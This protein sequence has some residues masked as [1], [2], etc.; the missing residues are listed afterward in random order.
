[1]IWHKIQ[2][3]NKVKKNKNN[4]SSSK[5]TRLTFHK[6]QQSNVTSMY[7]LREELLITILEKLDLV[8]LRVCSCGI[9]FEN[10]DIGKL[11]PNLRVLRLDG[12]TKLHESAIKNLSSCL[13]LEFLF[14]NQCNIREDIIDEL[15]STIPS[16]RKENVHTK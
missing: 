14:L 6:E 9:I 5:I 11:C 2:K 8:D 15:V 16:L 3:K 4:K 12:C 13:N 7:T 1:M 10:I